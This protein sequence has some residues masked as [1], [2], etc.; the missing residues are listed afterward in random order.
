MGIDSHGNN[1][2]SHSHTGCF[3]FLPI[4][5]A[6]FVTNSH[7]HGNPT[8]FPFP[9]GIP[10]PWSS[11][12]QKYK[13]NKH[14]KSARSPQQLSVVRTWQPTITSKRSTCLRK[15]QKLVQYVTLYPHQNCDN[16]AESTANNFLTRVKAEERLFTGFRND[17]LAVSEM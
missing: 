11:L 14:K 9:L 4:P 10:F 7:Y 15:R 3:P 13:N 16:Q 17:G 8:G 1:G 12:G 5:I 2:H 6:N